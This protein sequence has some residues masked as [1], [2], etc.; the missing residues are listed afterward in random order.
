MFWETNL[1]ADLV[2]QSTSDLCCDRESV[3]P[4]GESCVTLIRVN[5]I[6]IIPAGSRSV[7]MILLLDHCVKCISEYLVNKQLLNYTSELLFDS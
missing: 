4:C 6:L 1:I 5:F 3:T 2:P 7:I